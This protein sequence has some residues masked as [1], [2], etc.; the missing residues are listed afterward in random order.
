VAAGGVADAIGDIAGGGE[1]EI[2]LEIE[3][4]AALGGE[5]L[6]GED[7]G[8]IGGG[9]EVEGEAAGGGEGA[10][11]GEAGDD[12]IVFEGGEGFGVHGYSVAG[13]VDS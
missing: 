12:L 2:G 6:A 5:T 8:V 7:L 11:G 10:E 9:L 4:A 1:G 13:V 3:G